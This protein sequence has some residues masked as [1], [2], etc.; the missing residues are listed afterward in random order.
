[1]RRGQ[2]A[3]HIACS[4]IINTID[5]YSQLESETDATVTQRA[6]TVHVNVN[7]QSTQTAYVNEQTEN[8]C[9]DFMHRCISSYVRLH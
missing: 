6:F 8:H 1:M 7:A 3:T 4:N 5:I 2:R 9:I